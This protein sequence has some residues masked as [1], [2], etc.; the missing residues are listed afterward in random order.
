M[1]QPNTNDLKQ[2]GSQSTI[3]NTVETR[4][5]G[6]P[7]K[8]TITTKTVDSELIYKNGEWNQQETKTEE[9]NNL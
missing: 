3:T 8:E 2:R 4:V 5:N 7:T 9:T 6:V 1:A